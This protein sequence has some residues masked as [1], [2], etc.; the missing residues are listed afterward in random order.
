ML[1]S[2]ASLLFLL[3]SLA[4][5]ELASASELHVF[6]FSSAASSLVQALDGAASGSYTSF[7]AEHQVMVTAEA[8]QGVMAYS[9]ADSTF[10]IDSPPDA[11]DDY[12]LLTLT[13]SSPT[14]EPIHPVGISLDFLPGISPLLTS[15]LTMSFTSEMVLVA[16]AN[17]TIPNDMLFL[18]HRSTER[19]PLV[20]YFANLER[21]WIGLDDLTLA[22]GSSSLSGSST[23][24]VPEPGTVVLLFL[25]MLVVGIAR[26]RIR[27]E[28]LGST[29]SR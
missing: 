10:T 25:G 19:D 23:T 15:T 13:F 20:V 1:R 2:F 18:G 3:P 7:G 11:V 27:R 26:V 4:I 17:G 6:D 24:A 21:D 22:V 5:A 9:A 29:P 12:E 28:A 14:D 8:N 16:L